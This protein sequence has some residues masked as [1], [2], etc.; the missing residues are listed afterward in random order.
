MKNIKFQ[1]HTQT[2]FTFPVTIE[3]DS[4]DDPSGAV[5]TDLATKCGVN[6]SVAASDVS[7]TVRIKVGLSTG[8]CS[9]DAVLTARS[10]ACRSG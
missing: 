10:Y 8:G 5:I 4:A 2:N 9:A 6:P 1:D 3:Y 7:V